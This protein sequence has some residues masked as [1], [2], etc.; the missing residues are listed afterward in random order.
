MRAQGVERE[1]ADDLVQ[2]VWVALV[3]NAMTIEER[4]AVLKWLLI[5]AKRA[6]WEAVR[7]HRDEARRR[8]E[9]PD[10]T[11]EGIPELPAGFAS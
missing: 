10:D 2:T 3:R 1:Q 8:T 11:D 9:L 4:H 5:T 7:K 6:A